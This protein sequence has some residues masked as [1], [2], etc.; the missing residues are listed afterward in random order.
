MNQKRKQ[1]LII[2]CFLTF[3]LAIVVGLSMFALSENINLFYNP[4]QIEA[5][6][7]PQGVNLRAGGMVREGSVVRDQ[8]SLTIE[9]VLTDFASDVQVEYTGIL[10]D[11]FREGQGIVALGK[12]DENNVFV[13]EEVLAK[14]DEN[15]MPPEV[16]EALKKSGHMTDGSS[17][18]PYEGSSYG[19]GDYSS[20]SSEGYG[21][22]IAPA[23]T[24]M[25]EGNES[26][27]NSNYGD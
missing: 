10:P 7:A 14:H 1:R 15:Y 9:F 23:D 27:N 21:Q 17:P 4:T 11:L 22:T 12:L 16:A 3:G 8:E 19:S 20:R 2:V 5:G 26:Q 24:E 6:E 18:T 25:P 13:A